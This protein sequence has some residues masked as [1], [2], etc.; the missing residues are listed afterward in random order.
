MRRS[1][2]SFVAILCLLTLFVSSAACMA[3]AMPQDTLA[4]AGMQHQHSA[5][6]DHS[7]CPQ[8]NSAGEHASSTCCMVHHQ[9]VSAAAAVELAQ[10]IM[11]A[12]AVL[13]TQMMVAV[14]VYS[15]AS[16]STGPPQPPP[17]IALRI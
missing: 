1:F 6:A 3:V 12:Y 5:S 9:P 16:D 4:V 11:T 14:T 15:P 8:T 2:S 17:L 13:T 10:P 7:C